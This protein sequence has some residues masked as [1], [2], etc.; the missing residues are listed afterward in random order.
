MSAQETAR[1]PVAGPRGADGRRPVTIDG[2]R[3]GQIWRGGRGN[4]PWL[5][6]GS[7]DTWQG[8][9]A[10]QAAAL[11]DVVDRWTV[12]QAVDAEVSRREREGSPVLADGW[13]VASWDQVRPGQVV[14]AY[15]PQRTA[16]GAALAKAPELGPA[17]RV[18][19]I[20]R[21]GSRWVLAGREAG[22]R[23]RCEVIEPSAQPLGAVV[24]PGSR[25]LV[26]PCSRKKA[27]GV[28]R[29]AARELYTGTYH[30]ACLSAAE[31]MAEPGDAVLILSALHGLITPDTEIETYDVKAGDPDTV[32]AETLAYQALSMGVDK[33]SAVVLA[34][35][36][37]VD[38]ARHV[39]ET[40]ELP[41]AGTAGIGEQ[42]SRCAGIIADAAAAELAAGGVATEHPAAG[43]KGEG[44]DA[45]D[46]EDMAA[47]Y[48]ETVPADPA[49]HAPEQTR[50]ERHA[51]EHDRYMAH[52]E[53]PWL[54]WS[55][56]V[57]EVMAAVVAGD[58][59]ADTSGI[60]RRRQGEG[61]RVPAARVALLV[62]GA[63][64]RVPGEG[65]RGPLMPTEDGAKVA[66]MCQVFPEG[67]HQDDKTAQEA[68]RK[69]A[70]KPRVSSDRAKELSHTLEPLRGG[71]EE[72]RRLDAFMRWAEAQDVRQKRERAELDARQEAAEER[73]RAERA[74]AEAE[75]D[76]ERA[77]R[78]QAAYDRQFDG[79]VLTVHGDQHGGEFTMGKGKRRVTVKKI[80]E[81]RWHGIT[82]GQTYVIAEEKGQ[83]WP[84]VIVS[85]DGERI[86]NPSVIND[87]P[88]A[89]SVRDIIRA[90]AD[91]E[92][93]P[94]PAV[95][96]DQPAANQEGEASDD[97][98]TPAARDVPAYTPAPACRAVALDLNETR[99]GVECDRHGPQTMGLD[100]WG[101]PTEFEHKVQAYDTRAD[102]ELMA[103]DHLAGHAQTDADVMSPEEIE[104]AAAW[105]FSEA[106]SQVMAWIDDGAVIE[107]AEGFRADD[108][109]PTKFDVSAKI[110][111][112]RMVGLWRAGLVMVFTNGSGLRAFALTPEGR[113][114]WELWRNAR[115]IRAVE[116]AAEDTKHADAK[117]GKPYRL[118]SDG[119]LF[120]GE[121]EAAAKIDAKR[122]AEE[123]EARRIK[124]AE[125]I[126]AATIEEAGA[127]ELALWDA[128]RAEQATYDA[129]G[130]VPPEHT[131]DTAEVLAVLSAAIIGHT[132]GRFRKGATAV[133]IDEGAN[134]GDRQVTRTYNRNQVE[135]FATKEM[136]NALGHVAHN[137]TDDN[138]RA[139]RPLC[140]SL[141][142][143]YRVFHLDLTKAMEAG[144]ALLAQRA[145]ADP[146]TP[147]AEATEEAD[148]GDETS[149]SD[150]EQEAAAPVVQ[151]YTG[152]EEETGA[153]QGVAGVCSCGA[154]IVKLLDGSRPV[155]S[156]EGEEREGGGVVVGGYVVT[157]AGYG[158]CMTDFHT[159]YGV[160]RWTCKNTVARCA[161]CVAADLG[162]NTGALP[163]YRDGDDVTETTRKAAAG[164]GAEGSDETTPA[165]HLAKM[166]ALVVD[167]EDA[168]DIVIRH[169]R[170]DG[171]SV[172]GNT[173]P[174]AVRDILKRKEYGRR[175]GMGF[176]WSREVEAWVLYH[177]RDHAADDWTINKLSGYL[178]AEL[179]L[180]VCIVKDNAKRRSYAE[181]QAE[182]IERAE[183][184]AERYAE[185][186]GNASARSEG[187]WKASHAIADHMTGEPIKVGHHSERR[188]RRTIE[189][190]DNHMH[191]SIEEEK[192]AA[193]WALRTR[194]A[195]RFEAFKRDPWRTLRRI[196][197]FE[198]EQRDNERWQAG[199]SACGYFRSN[200]E[201]LKIEAEEIAE[202]LAF[203]REVIAEA[204]RRGFKIWGPDDFAKGDFVNTGGTWREVCR[205]NKK[206]LTVPHIHGGI[207]KAVHRKP[208][209]YKP[210][211]GYTIPYDAVC[212]WA[213]AE[214]IARM[215]AAEAEPET[216]RTACPHCGQYVTK[217]RPVYSQARGR[218]L[219]CGHAK[220]QNFKPKPETP[221][222][223]EQKEDQGAA[224]A[225]TAEPRPAETEQD[226]DGQA[227][228]AEPV[229]VPAAM[230]KAPADA[231]ALCLAAAKTIR[232]VASLRV[233]G[234]RCTLSTELNRSGQKATAEWERDGSGWVFVRAYGWAPGVPWREVTTLEGARA[235][236]LDPDAFKPAA[237][238][239][240]ESQPPAEGDAEHQPQPAMADNEER[241]TETA[242]DN[243]ANPTPAVPVTVEPTP[244]RWLDGPALVFIVSQNTTPARTRGLYRVT[245]EEA[246][247]LCSHPATSGK[248]Y[249][250]CWTERPGVLGEDFEFVT[251]DGRFTGVLA[252]LGITPARDWPAE[253]AAAF[254]ASCPQCFDRD[255]FDG[256]T[257]TTCEKT[258]AELA[259]AHQEEPEEESAEGCAHCG[260]SIQPGRAAAER[261]ATCS[262]SHWLYCTRAADQ[263]PEQQEPEAPAGPTPQEV[264]ALAEHYDSAARFMEAGPWP[265]GTV[266]QRREKF[267]AHFEQLRARYSMAAEKL[268]GLVAAWFEAPAPYE[269]PAEPRQAIEGAPQRA[270]VEAAPQRLALMAAPVREAIEA[271]PVRLALPAALVRPRPA[272]HP[273][274]LGPVLIP[275][276][277]RAPEP[278]P[279]PVVAPEPVEVSGVYAGDLV[280]DDFD[281]MCGKLGDLSAAWDAV[282]A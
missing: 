24:L 25:V 247:R 239:A 4:R 78:E 112:A 128:L 39:W 200:M 174:K 70:K 21:Q 246:Q 147:A 261:T 119:A 74:A 220:P 108:V 50:R 233:E 173:R 253:E 100:K 75:R 103:A 208:E 188:H 44:S 153:P 155:C 264:A 191:R 106:Q 38:L 1:G 214:D 222:E 33:C 19:R 101:Q 181:A 238:P 148:P 60:V 91:G 170:A 202:K 115:R 252:E 65:K 280:R 73:E 184:R 267:A 180:K 258:A 61:R 13:T 279:A 64:I 140:S 227:A 82:R 11:A 201:E 223:Y 2:Q 84:W 149:G 268:T 83:D 250:L 90:H 89:D 132:A 135:Q 175:G 146:D 266:A 94:Q 43:A 278:T 36:A 142:D 156:H 211:D 273:A 176:R 256:T 224:D 171:T 55:A 87:Q 270:A 47:W 126:A 265:A 259:A 80:T 157:Q 217:G 245:R 99:F 10:D 107:T 109:S 275:A 150:Q 177:S 35:A 136:T 248:S 158:T 41:F 207:G 172:E 234:D 8:A 51:W 131:P 276:P 58:L 111:K 29:A 199:Q 98:E 167:D 18:R 194:A 137:L 203:E 196:E 57:A 242:T 129:A 118:L 85:P 20:D 121:A 154:G 26:V 104:E 232:W 22:G 27:P 95:T 230:L 62:S 241:R 262:A 114:A 225:A 274:D 56:G 31:A 260:R 52:H 205:V 189:R 122:Q 53:L 14:R 251:D 159:L 254:P 272:V 34:G 237:E 32:T 79:V 231:Q 186:A 120:D 282:T 277:R 125:A 143:K 249:M 123:D 59:A 182:Q 102:A 3:A 46:G 15:K 81:G 67:L 168:A 144:R 134:P 195:E 204:E 30:R 163:G 93:L 185:Y 240:A 216:E 209:G 166:T 7:V 116:H 17:F 226:D 151:P 110:S 269:A 160:A 243:E 192:K 54:N 40:P 86:G 133:R 68:R 141:N 76:R 139:W 28:Q 130:D 23:V 96:A 257:C 164:E 183:A 235:L 213:S 145:T 113:R 138:A 92:A 105:A 161:F 178:R 72:R 212:G 165:E 198:K 63:F 127:E 37:Y 193:Y 255:A 244:A 71:A 271:V 179:G 162:V 66:R 69:A 206:T 16:S 9:H 187:A 97:I 12:V 210:R 6:V 219:E 5:A 218:C 229:L 281:A 88:Y 221:A 117:D 77:E 197:K 215:D 169:T 49:Q 263:E 42:L 124:E 236:F 190:M 228:E 152:Q 45:D 48:A